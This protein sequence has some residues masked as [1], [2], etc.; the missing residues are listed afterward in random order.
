MAAQDRT[1]NEV[2]SVGDEMLVPVVQSPSRMS[3]F[4]DQA[5]VFPTAEGAI[6]LILMRQEIAIKSQKGRVNSVSPGEVEIE[7][8]PHR[9][10]HELVDIAH[11]RLSMDQAVQTALTILG[12]AQQSLGLSEKDIVKR[13]RSL[14]VQSI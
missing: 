11:V 13:L 6:E 4:P 1:L 10:G 3:Y 5:L 14:T 8:Q 2:P 7:F 9:V 12:V